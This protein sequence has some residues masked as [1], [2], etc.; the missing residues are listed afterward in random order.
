M[1]TLPSNSLGEEE[2]E[3]TTIRGLLRPPPI[4]G[5]EAWGI[6]DAPDGEV[7]PAVAVRFS[8]SDPSHPMLT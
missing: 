3:M 4:P 2:D 1:D 5:I 7:N 8:Y 6:P